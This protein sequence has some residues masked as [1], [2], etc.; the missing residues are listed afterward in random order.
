MVAAPLPQLAGVGAGSG[1]GCPEEESRAARPSSGPA[2][3]GGAPAP[4]AFAAPLRGVAVT[5]SRC[6]CCAS[7]SCGRP[8]PSVPLYRCHVN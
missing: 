8:S 6:P 5:G 2:P 4:Q 7:A 1:P 3:A